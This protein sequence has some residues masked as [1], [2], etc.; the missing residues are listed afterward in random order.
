MSPYSKWLHKQNRKAADLEVEIFWEGHKNL[1]HLPPIIWRLKVLRRKECL[2]DGTVTR[3][4]WLLYLGAWPL[5]WGLWRMVIFQIVVAFSDN[6]NFTKKSSIHKCLFILVCSFIREFRVYRIKMKISSE[7]FAA[8]TDSH[9]YFMKII[10]NGMLQE[11]F[12]LWYYCS[13]I[14]FHLLL[15]QISELY[16]S[17]FLIT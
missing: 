13:F 16:W 9:K 3:E 6:L 10:I 4:F 15:V 12:D 17:V 8:F 14:C 2:S 1:A 11:I 7:I 5:T